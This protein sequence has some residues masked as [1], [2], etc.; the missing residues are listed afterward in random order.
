MNSY[1]ILT[2]LTGIVFVIAGWILKKFPPRKINLMYGYWTPLSMKNQESWEAGNRYSAKMMLRSGTLL[3]LIS[4][5][6]SYL[7]FS[8]MSGIIAGLILLLG[9]CLTVYYLTENH[10]KKIQAETQGEN[11]LKSSK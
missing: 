8:E 7:P 2:L 5:A 11:G 3:M 10:L 6:G 9:V 4:P 1:T